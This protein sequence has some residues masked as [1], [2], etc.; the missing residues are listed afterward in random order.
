MIEEPIITAV[1]VWRDRPPQTAAIANARQAI[2]VARQQ[3]LSLLRDEV[4]WRDGPQCHYC[5]VL[6]PGYSDGTHAHDRTVDHK[7]P[8]DRGGKDEVD[9]LVICCRKCNSQKGTLPYEVFIARCRPVRMHLL[10]GAGFRVGQQVHHQVFGDGIV[11]ATMGGTVVV[12][13]HGRTG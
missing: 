11:V 6:T 13:G 7:I 2:A 10:G 1:P 9:N 8:V 3:L 5:G 4:L 12:F